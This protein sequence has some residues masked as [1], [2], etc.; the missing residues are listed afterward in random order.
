MENSIFEKIKSIYIQKILF[1]F[2]KNENFKFKLFLYSKYFQKKFELERVDFKEK[3]LNQSK[4][5]LDNYLCCYSLFN[6]DPKIFD[7]NLMVKRVEEDLAKY[8]ID[9]NFIHDCLIN[10]FKKI[11]KTLTEKEKENKLAKYYYFTKKV[12]ILSPFFDFISQTEYF[13]L[14]TIPISTKLIEKYNLKNEYITTFEKLNKL[15]LKKYPSILFEY[16]KTEDINYLKEFRIKFNKIKG[17]SASHEYSIYINNYDYFFQ[18]LFSL[19]NI[20]KNLVHLNLYVGFIKMDRIDPNS[21]KNLNCF[22]SLE[23]LE[24]KGF[25]FKNPFILKIKNL[26][27]LILKNCENLTFGENSCL[28]M[29]IL[30]LLDCSFLNP[31]SL[32]KLPELEECI[33]QNVM[34]IKQKYNNIIDFS[35]LEKIKKLT[36]ETSDF[37]NIKN[38]L[39]ESVSLYS[40][41]IS[42]ETEKLMIEKLI[43]IKTLKDINIEIKEIG[44]NEILNIHGENNSV[45]NMSVKWSNNIHDCILTNLQKK[46]PFSSNLSIITPYKRTEIFLEI[47]EEP[48][49]KINK[50]CMKIGGNKNILFHCQS[51]ENLV[52]VD[53]NV[54]GNIINIIDAFPLF[55]D[56]CKIEFK[57]LIY[58]KY[59][60][61]SN[62]VTFNF[63]KNIYNNLD[64]IPNLKS[65][66]LQGIS[67]DIT[68]QFYFK[69][70]EKVLM[71]R[72]NYI[73]LAIKKKKDDYTNYIYKDEELIKMFPD[74]NYIKYD[75][76]TIR[77]L[78]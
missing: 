31:K 9:M 16:T 57:S 8:K 28:N 68:G 50:L 26:K 58:F 59:T 33:L 35:S 5:E 29:K 10:D 25:K 2:I 51:F 66:E 64:K 69:L 55:N 45:I 12:N 30:F 41:N 1:E 60:N 44:D 4:I 42:E 14:V 18:T 27:K 22:L 32:L 48:S 40:Y 38:T 56:E 77:K 63:F 39:L 37:I 49:F 71:L 46:F 3:Y 67:K 75:K 72:L 15:N 20:E 65:F 70:I 43:S 24:L 11:V 73:F 34:N 61:Y 13:D 6:V 53:I 76:V 52:S 47:K 7:K 62:E 17:F 54:N 78:N 23:V 19:N 74:I 36:A 21:L